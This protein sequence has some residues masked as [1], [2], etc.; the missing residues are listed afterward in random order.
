MGILLWQTPFHA[1][2]RRKLLR[3]ITLFLGDD[4]FGGKSQIS[5]KLEQDNQDL[6]DF[7]L[8]SNWTI[9]DSYDKN[10]TVDL[11]PGFP[12]RLEFNSTLFYQ[13]IIPPKQ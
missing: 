12:V 8:N 2:Q 10:A 13:T 9:I 4:D 1:I 6:A 11:K 7:Q 3:D 5:L